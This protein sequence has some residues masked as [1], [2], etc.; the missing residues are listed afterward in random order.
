MVLCS[1]NLRWLI[2]SVFMWIR[3]R[4]FQRHFLYLSSY[5]KLTFKC[6]L[7]KYNIRN[8]VTHCLHVPGNLRCIW[9]KLYKKLIHCYIH[10]VF[11]LWFDKRMIM[12][13]SLHSIWNLQMPLEWS[14]RWSALCV[15]LR[16]RL[17][18]ERHLGRLKSLYRLNN[19]EEP[20][21]FHTI[22]VFVFSMFFY[23]SNECHCIRSVKICYNRYH[24]CRNFP[25]VGGL[26]IRYHCLQSWHNCNILGFSLPLSVR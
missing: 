24:W 5:F 4:E 14:N 3:S 22:Y 26:L 12:Q 17:P 2:L 9:N 21:L 25:G 10:S 13:T 7:D 6:D 15:F 19:S 1:R 11:Y 16:N 8:D 18:N 23:F 20:P